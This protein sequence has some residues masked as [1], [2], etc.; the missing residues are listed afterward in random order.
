MQSVRQTRKHF[1]PNPSSPPSEVAAAIDRLTHELKRQHWL[2]VALKYNHNTAR[3]FCGPF[4]K[5]SKD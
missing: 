3:E 5:G 2:D 4:P 1:E